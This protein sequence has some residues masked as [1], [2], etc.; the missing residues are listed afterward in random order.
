MYNWRIDNIYVRSSNGGDKHEEDLNDY[1]VRIALGSRIWVLVLNITLLFC[2][3]LKS[4]FSH[5]I[6]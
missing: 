2:V 5:I 3:Y 6:L 4:L 1:E